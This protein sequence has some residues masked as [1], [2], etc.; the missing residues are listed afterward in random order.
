MMLVGVL[1]LLA[2]GRSTADVTPMAKVVELLNNLQTEV[3]TEG[4]AEAES[5]DKFAC[6]C[7]DTTEEKVDSINTKEDSAE[8]LGAEEARLSAS[9]S[10]LKADISKLTEDIGTAETELKKMTDL[11]E[12]EHADYMVSYADLTK[13][14]DSLARAITAIE[15]SKMSLA[16]VRGIINPVLLLADAMSLVPT[17]SS[18]K[19]AA[20]LEEGEEPEKPDYEFHSG[21][22]IGTLEDLKTDFTQKKSDVQSEEDAAES[23]FNTAADAKRTE[24]STAKDT[25]DTKEGELSTDEASLAD[26]T[27]ELTETKALMHDDRKYLKDLTEQCERKANEWDQRSTMRTNELAAI[28][29]ALEILTESVSGKAADSGAGGRSAAVGAELQLDP[30]ENPWEGEVSFVQVRKHKEIVDD[31]ALR[32][33]NRV[34]ALLKANSVDLHSPEISL[35]AMK[36]AED[37]F[38]KVK[39]LIQQLIQRLLTESKNEATHKGWCDTE[40]GKAKHSRDARHKDVVSLTADTEVME[41]KKAKLIVE[42]DTLMTEI[43]ELTSALTNATN[44]RGEEKADHEAT[45][46]TAQE[47]LT[48]L[49]EA[50]RVLKDF[51]S[52]SSRATVLVQASPVDEDMAAAGTGGFDGAYQGNQAQGE[53]ILGLLATIKSDF[54]R[55]LSETE[56]AEKE[57]YTDFAA[58]SKETKAS[59][60]AKKTGVENA[61]ADLVTTSGDLVVAL[62]DLQQNQKLMDNALEALEKLRPACID[63]GMSYEERV[64]RREAEI[65]ALKQA[66][67][68][69]DEG[70]KEIA[71]CNHAMFLQKR[72]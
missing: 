62:M 43:V 41:A 71:E 23:S 2:E 30:D 61:E 10:Q 29:Q 5:Y 46:K 50:I 33:R 19:V 8:Q 28:S 15:G 14:V 65:E 66:L 53:G 12:Q 34:I 31:E 20:L 69:L 26:T 13:A 21:D 40:L 54:E 51:Y 52:S 47:G 45:M 24:I 3:Q 6:F 25:L 56:A 9:V 7:K 44:D 17:H 27:G 60:S 4:T 18:K 63:T 32:P 39:V 1:L 35:L 42:K 11:R 38:A 68:V 49:E 36:I 55:T 22:I 16:Q 58:F 64:Q 70:D 37:P 67:C 59:I 48:A 57:S 72:A